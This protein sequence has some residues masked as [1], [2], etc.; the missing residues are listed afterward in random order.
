MLDI[1]PPV[2][3]SECE[4]WYGGHNGEGY[5]AI[6]IDGRNHPAHVISY[7]LHNGFIPRGWQI[8]HRCRNK[9]CINPKHL[10]LATPKQ[11]QENLPVTGNGRSGVRGVCWVGQ[12]G[13]W[14]PQVKHNGKL[15][16]FG[17][18]ATIEEAA[19]VVAEKR[20]ELFTHNDADR[21]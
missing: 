13:R 20:R 18:C 5:G 16:T 10:R 2:D 21:M 3:Q 17:T 4:T 6:V 15:L 1:E 11:N 19:A 9:G 12:L 14:R 8:D 7:R